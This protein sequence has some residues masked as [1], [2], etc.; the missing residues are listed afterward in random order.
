MP[1]IH[2]PLLQWNSCS[3]QGVGGAFCCPQFWGHSS[4]PSAQSASPSHAHTVQVGGA[5]EASSLPSEQSDSSSHT[6]EPSSS[7]PFSQ[8]AF[9]S[10]SHREGTHWFSLSPQLNSDG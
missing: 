9:P 6:N 8:S 10:Q 7:R 4:E 1:W 5:Q 3:W 2:S